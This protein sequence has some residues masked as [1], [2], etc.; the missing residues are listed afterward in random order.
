M[1]LST[2]CQTADTRGERR[3]SIY[4]PAVLY[5]DGDAS[6]VK[7]CNVSSVGA[8]LTGEMLPQAGSLVQLIRGRLI[9]HGLLAWRDAGWCGVQFS[10]M[11]DVAR[12]RASNAEQHRVDE[13]VRL[14][15]A[16]VVPLP[17][18]SRP[19]AKR[20][21]QTPKPGPQLAGDLRR[22]SEIIEN[23]GGELAGDSS[24]IERH[25]ALLQH[26]D[27][28]VQLLD[29]IGMIVAGHMDPGEAAGKLAA[30]RRSADQALQRNA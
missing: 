14:V 4:L 2:P 3:S 7:I 22:V 6:D 17:T 26:I 13:V 16:G 8:L 10:G 24:V 15:K 1:P 30:L 20:N 29:E 27:I 18:S 5:C 9:A 23:L 25:G 12:W 28:A 19:T 11:V 21:R